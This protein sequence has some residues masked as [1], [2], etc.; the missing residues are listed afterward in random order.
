MRGKRKDLPNTFEGMEQHLLDAWE[1][2]NEGRPQNPELA[3]L[4]KKGKL[5]TNP[6]TVALEAGVSRTLIG[7]EKCRYLDVRLKILGKD[8][9]T[10]EIPVR[11]PTDM[12]TINANLREINRTLESRLKVALSNQAAVLNR[13]HKL[14]TEYNDRLEEI[15]RINSRATRNPNEV[16]GLHIVKPDQKK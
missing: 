8:A 7:H 6:T 3:L 12:R 4:A 2:V 13:M 16:V 9:E 15:K 14:E 1:R 11:V 5:K 10:E